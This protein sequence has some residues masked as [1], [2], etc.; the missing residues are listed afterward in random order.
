MTDDDN[1]L[2]IPRHGAPV[3]AFELRTAA[4]RVRQHGLRDNDRTR[5]ILAR[6][7]ESAADGDVPADAVTALA[8]QVRLPW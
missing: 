1:P 4:S 2:A 5:K 6:I 3:N 7:F 8:G